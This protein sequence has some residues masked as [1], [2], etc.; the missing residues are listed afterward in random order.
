MYDYKNA[1]NLGKLYFL[2][3]IHKNLFNVPGHP[4]ISNC[5]TPTEK[6]SEFLDRH[7]KP[8]MQSSRSCIKDSGDFLTK[9]K[10]IGNL[11][12]NSIIVTVDVIGLHPSIP[13]EVGLKA[14]EEAL[15]KRDPQ[16]ISTDD[17]IK[18]VKFVLQNN[19]FEFNREFKQQISGTTIG[20][21]F[22]PPYACIFTDQVES[23]F[24]KTQ[25]HQ[26]LV[27]FR[28]I[29][30]I[31][32]IWTH[33][34]EKLEGF[35]DYFTKF[36]PNLRFTHEYS[37]K[38]VTFLDLDVK[39]VDGKIFTDLHIKDTDRNQYLHYTSSHLYHTKRSI[40]YSQD[41]RVSRICSFE[42]GFI[43]L[44]NKMKSWFLNRGHPKTLTDTKVNKVKFPWFLN[45]G[46]PQNIDRYEG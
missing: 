42:N 19:Y 16:Q 8:V 44:R 14:L 18:L 1:I 45:R 23:E 28:Y 39:I 11:P 2:P 20:T 32:F 3:K 21:K 29:D 46:H 30:D 33:G 34:Q 36:H 12:E 5:G 35:L 15:E 43:R 10:Q 17:L 31:F 22:A 4:V 37:R 26:P 9:I 27:W 25:Q 24:L 6:A 13:H 7:L 41:L 38:N 40:V